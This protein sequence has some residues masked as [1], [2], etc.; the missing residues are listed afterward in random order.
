[1]DSAGRCDPFEERLMHQGSGT[2]STA[3]EILGLP[4]R[5]WIERETLQSKFVE[6]AARWHPDTNPDPEA[7]SRFQALV[8]AHLLL[9]DPV[10][11]LECVLQLEAPTQATAQTGAE[12]T[13]ELTE[14]FLS[15]AT[16]NRQLQA[17]HA[18]QPATQSTL[19]RALLQSD[20]LSLGHDLEQLN[21]RVEHHWQRCETQ[22]HAADFIW[23]R[24][25][26]ELLDSLRKVLREMAFLQRW[27][28]QLRE[29]RVRL[30]QTE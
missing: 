8:G 30:T 26:P 21:Q 28:V 13:Q 12:I 20:R 15:I 1:M 27:R 25:T 18:Q 23:D 17:F 4:V 19:S 2:P 24:R 11:R 5:P 22:I 16:F 29:S 10:K 6:L 14:L 3:F 7:A 9:R